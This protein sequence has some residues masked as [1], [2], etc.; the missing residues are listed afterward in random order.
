MSQTR[1][2]PAVAVVSHRRGRF[3]HENVMPLMECTA[4]G[5][6]VSVSTSPGE[7]LKVTL[8]VRFLMLINS[9]CV[10]DRAGLMVG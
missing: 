10:F 7:K 3:G 5:A 9:V 2:W 1:V 6:S 4:V 8:T